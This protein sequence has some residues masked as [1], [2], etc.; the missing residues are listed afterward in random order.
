MALPEAS[1]VVSSIESGNESPQGSDLAPSPSTELDKLEKFTF[2]GKEYTP[3]QVK[4]W[5]DNGLRQADYTRKTQ[6]FSQERRF[7]EN[8]SADLKHVRGNPALVA[9][10]RRIYPEKFWGYLEYVT[11]QAGTPSTQPDPGSSKSQFA[12]IDPE[13]VARFERLEQSVTQRDVEAISA[14][15]EAQEKTLGSKYPMADIEAVYAKAQAFLDSQAKLPKDEQS[16]L[17]PEL[18]DKIYKADH[19]KHE[20][21]YVAR[22]KENVNK[23]KQAGLKARDSGAGGGMPGAAP[24]THKSIREARDALLADLE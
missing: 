24:K 19:D 22:Y 23:Q 13:M 12:S 8:L 18:W 3:K 10:F 7:Y 14:N 1:E 5:R 16:K 17:T 20:A 9:E 15:L 11:G 6:E 21:R 2:E 4:E